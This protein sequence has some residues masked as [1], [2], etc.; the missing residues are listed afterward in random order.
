MKTLYLECSMGAAGDML[1]AAIL[2]LFEDNEKQIE[3]LNN[4]GIEGISFEKVDSFKCGIKGTRMVVKINGEEEKIDEHEH[5]HEHHHHHHGDH[6]HHHHHEDHEHTHSHHHHEHGHH[7]HRS[8]KDIEE[9][10]RNIKVSEKVKKDIME[11]YKHIAEA[12][13]VAHNV[14]V[15]EIHFHEVGT[16]DAI[17]DITAVCFLIDE[18]EVEKIIASPINV[19]SGHV[20]CAHGILPVPAPATAYILKDVPMYTSEIRGELCTPTGAAILKH[21]VSKFEEMPKLRVEKIGYGMGKKDFERINC[22]RAFLGETKDSEE[23]VYELSCNVDDMSAEE[24]SFAMDRF[25]EAGAKEVYT[26]PIGMKKSRPGTLIKVMC[27]EEDKSNLLELIFKHTTTIGIRETQ[28]SRYILDRNIEEIETSL[29]TIRFKKSYGY[30][31]SRG[32]FEYDDLS[33]IARENN[34]SIFEVKEKIRKK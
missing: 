5:H 27:R 6:E 11:V 21:F 3:N 20:H 13:S 24:I 4:L 15:S 12:E 31:V 25:F 14:D 22:V 9:I 18:L 1:T 33:K 19:G 23:I 2:E 34:L 16:M 7:V 30:G 10:V 26:V 28:T 8:M 32:K 29:G 17:A